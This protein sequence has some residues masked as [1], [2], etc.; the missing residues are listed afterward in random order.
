MSLRLARSTPSKVQQQSLG[1]AAQMPGDWQGTTA[2]DED[3]GLPV[4]EYSE[5]R[6][7]Q[8]LSEANR[9]ML[10]DPHIRSKIASSK[11]SGE[12]KPPQIQVDTACWQADFFLA[13]APPQKGTRHGG[14]EEEK[15]SRAAFLVSNRGG[16]VITQESSAAFSTVQVA[17]SRDP[18]EDTLPGRDALPSQPSQRLPQRSAQDLLDFQHGAPHIKLNENS[19]VNTKS[20]LT[21]LNE[22]LR[23][24]GQDQQLLHYL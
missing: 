17:R 5:G 19:S 3:R 8:I 2:A 1:M 10:S 11:R 9:Q 12:G 21:L 24:P 15:Q 18:R 14:P 20:Q 23:S 22:N 4:N 13:Q 7:I 16:G 6:S